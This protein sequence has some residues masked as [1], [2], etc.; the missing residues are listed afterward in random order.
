MWSAASKASRL[1]SIPLIPL[2]CLLHSTVTARQTVMFASLFGKLKAPDEANEP[3]IPV[4][5]IGPPTSRVVADH[6]SRPI[7]WTS[8]SSTRPSLPMAK[9]NTTSSM[10]DE[11]STT[12]LSL[13]IAQHSSSTRTGRRCFQDV[14]GRQWEDVASRFLAGRLE[15]PSGWDL[16]MPC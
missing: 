11:P 16:T 6:H 14:D 15:E 13:T 12:V 5:Q 7:H 8:T 9:S 4:S 1:F 3:E 2:R 10:S